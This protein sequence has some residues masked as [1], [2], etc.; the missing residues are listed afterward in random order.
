M[1]AIDAAF[2]ARVARRVGGLEI[3][4][5]FALPLFSVA[6]RV[7]GL[8]SLPATEQWQRWVARRV[9]GLEM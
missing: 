9:G 1:L 8:E 6:R 2:T 7:G 4:N 5:H 3:F